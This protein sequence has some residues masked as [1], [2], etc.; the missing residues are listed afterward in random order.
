[1]NREEIIKN[2]NKKILLTVGFRFKHPTTYLKEVS[3]VDA[4]KAIDWSAHFDVKE[5]EDHI[6]LDC[7]SANDMW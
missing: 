5:F 7:Y 1:M 6:E 2:T 4:I 3:K